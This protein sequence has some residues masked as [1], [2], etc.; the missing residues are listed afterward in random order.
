MRSSNRIEEIRSK[1]AELFANHGYG[2]VGVAELGE[3]VGLGKGALYH[4]ISSK[5]E[6]LYDISTRYIEGLIENG[7]DIIAKELDP[8]ERIKAL[9][10][11]MIN[12]VYRHRAEMTV[13]FREIHSLS[14]ER[15]QRVSQLHNDYQQLWIDTIAMG[16]AQKKFRS[17]EKTAIKGIMGMFFYSF[18]WL[19]PEGT[20]NADQ[21]GDVFSDF[22]L[23]SL[24]PWSD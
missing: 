4:H 20:Q 12:V 16:V 8:S 14:G 6:L 19:K 22:I 3:A 10:R 11:A 5:E 24:I 17:I 23:H 21:V 7:R 1:A 9:S 15:H 2:A 18:L 13:C